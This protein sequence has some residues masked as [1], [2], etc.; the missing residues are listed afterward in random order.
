MF[1]SSFLLASVGSGVSRPEMQAALDEQAIRFGR[2][3]EAQNAQ[4]KELERVVRELRVTASTSDCAAVQACVT[5]KC[6]AAVAIGAQSCY[7]Q[8]PCAVTCRETASPTSASPASIV[9]ASSPAPIGSTLQHSVCGPT[10]TISPYLASMSLVYAWAPDVVYGNASRPNS[11][12]AM[13]ARAHKLRTARYPA[14][15]AS[16]WNWEDPSGAM[17]K[18]TLDPA[19]D[20]ADRVPPDQWMS[21][22]EYL[23]LCGA[24][25]LRPLIGVNYNCH[26]HW[27]V[28]R[29]ESVARA[30]RQVQHA[31]HRGFSGAFWYVG[32]EDGALQHGEAIAAHAR[33]MKA[34]DPSA[35]ILFNSNGLE[36]AGLEA[37]LAQVGDAVDGAEFHGKWPYGGEPELPPATFAEWLQEVPLAE[38]KSGKTW[39]GRLSELRAAAVRAG[40]PE[41]LLANNEYGLG[42][43]SRLVGFTRYTK[44]LVAVEF[45]L[46]MYVAGF[47]IAAFWD[48]GDGGDGSHADQ[49]RALNHPCSPPALLPRPRP[50]RPS[51]GRHT[52]ATTLHHVARRAQVA[53]GC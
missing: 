1:S 44:A 15:E 34:V 13:W 21:F 33:A 28:P 35:K 39:R 32:N 7:P 18:S 38:R 52:A 20:D 51:P 48:N 47:D 10:R 49:A 29:N 45:A 40:R 9:E 30:V 14:G 37:F 36:P 11:T 23:D 6:T 41:L 4:L 8:Q 5:G 3:L 19:F 26:G 22:D 2:L 24:A 16:Y 25:A 50:T 27:W 31:I 46:E 53:H 42:K 17:G 12:M 43:P